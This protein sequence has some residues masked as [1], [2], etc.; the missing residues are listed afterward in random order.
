VKRN[1]FGDREIKTEQDDLDWLYQARI[2]DG[3]D[4]ISGKPLNNMVREGGLEPPHLT[5]LEPKSSASTNSATPALKVVAND[6]A[7]SNT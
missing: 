4:P 7:I 1:L 3:C 6:K 5:V 2:L